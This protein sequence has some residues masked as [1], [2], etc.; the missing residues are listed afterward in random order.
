MVDRIT[1]ATTEA[2]RLAIADEFGPGDAWPVV[3]EPFFQWVLED[4]FPT[5]RPPLERAGVQLVDDVL[6]YELMKLRLLN[7]G[8]Q[9]LCYFGRLLG[10][11]YVH[12]AAQDPLIAALLRRYWDEEAIP[13]LLPLPGTDLDL[14]TSTLLERFGNPYV[15]D[16]IAR[17]CTDGSDRIPQWLVPVIQARQASAPMAAAIVASWARY[18]EGTDEAGDPIEIVDRRRDQ[19]L[20]FGA[21]VDG[22]P[23]AF[24]RQSDL[25]GDLASQ[26]SFTHP[27]EQALTLLRNQGARATL[28]FLL[29]S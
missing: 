21:P 26:P 4:T 20:S 24:L 14:Y 1:P 29:A 6:P 5:G 22:D 10:Y 2:D 12:D 9:G 18:C 23:L 16:T 28:E 15:Q 7:A 8:H 17:L 13:T 27:Y 3:A 11:H 25:F 19:L